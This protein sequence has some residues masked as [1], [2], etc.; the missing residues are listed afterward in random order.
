MS[1]AHGG[2]D[3]TNT[4]L[5]LGH[6]LD[7]LL[8][9]LHPITPYVTEELWTTLTGGESLVIAPWPSPQPDYFDDDAGREIALVQDVVTEARRFRADQGVRPAQR[10]RARLAGI[11][12]SPLIPHEEHVRTLAR[13]DLPGDGF[14]TTASL[15]VAGLIVEIDL[16]GSIDVAA[17]RARLARDL[18]AAEKERTQAIVKLDTPDFVDKA[19]VAVVEKIRG[20]LAAAE[21]DLARIS[22]Q[23][24]R[25]PTA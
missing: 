23:L 15:D 5:V 1:I 12:A 24:D 21:A 11:E 13:L 14:A 18:A 9:M 20:R 3:A 4:R 6:V 8:R 2:D 16:S 10:V 25:L 7:A 22:A 17:E 19:P